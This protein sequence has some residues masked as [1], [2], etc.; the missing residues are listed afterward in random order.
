MIESMAQGTVEQAVQPEVRRAARRNAKASLAVLA[1]PLL[2]AVLAGC[3][4]YGK[5]VNQEVTLRLTENEERAEANCIVSNDLGTWTVV[6]P[7]VVGVTRSEKPLL[8][9]CSTPEG[10]KAVGVFESIKFGELPG[11]SSSYGYPEEIGLA[12][13]RHDKQR[14]VAVRAP[15]YASLDDVSNLPYVDEEGVEGYRRF[16]AGG[17][18]RAFAISDNGHWIRVNAAR[19]AAR[20]AISRCQTY[21]GRCRLYAVDDEVVWDQKRA[22]DLVASY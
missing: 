14:P 20:L 15:A 7:V 11:G 2:A 17:L 1:V 4:S 19:G 13:V 9:E 10:S 16:L 8:V 12:L 6:A 21:G 18:P 3:A 5:P 22:N